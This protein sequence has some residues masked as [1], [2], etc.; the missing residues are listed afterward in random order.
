MKRRQFVQAAAAASFAG[1]AGTAAR[2]QGWPEKPV[3]L[4]LSQPPGSGP[5][6]MA[7]M[8]GDQLARKWGQSIVVDNRPG[9]QNAI[10]AQAAARSPADG[11]NFY[12]A[13]AAAL[14][15]N[16]Y[17]FKSLP[18]DPKKDFT[19]VGMIGKVPF[20][21]CVNTGSPVKSLQEFIA[22]AKAHPG[23]LTVANEG[24][25]TFGGMMTRL[26]GQQLGLQLSSVPY[27][28]IGAAVTGTIGAQTDAVM[29]DVPAV[30]QQVKAGRLRPIAVTTAKR[31]AGLEDVPSLS[32][33]IPGFDYA[34]WLGIVAPAGTPAAAIQR[35]NRDLDAVLSDKEMAARILALGPI[36]DG[37]GTVEQMAA[38]LQAEHTRWSKLTQEL[39]ILPE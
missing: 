8:I 16:A 4:I 27:V 38:F 9:G 11:Y 2:A 15:T 12:F 7:R 36:T 14:V 1:L 34:G 19:P 28:S 13:T 24:P 6:A 3:K 29:A 33:V 22:Q 20:M 10:G 18:Y 30:V 23:R 5:D 17:L 35:F 39:G 26:V 25:K 32:E 21:L 31:V 37:A